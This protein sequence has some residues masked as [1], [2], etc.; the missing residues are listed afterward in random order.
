MN[1]NFRFIITIFLVLFISFLKANEPKPPI[2]NAFKSAILPGWG[3]LSMGNKSGY[4]FL[5]IEATLWST[6]FYFDDQSDLRLRQADQFA[7]NNANLKSYDL[8]E[9]LRFLLG[10]FNTSGF[11]P[12]GYN[13]FVITTAK[14]LY[15]NQP[16]KQTDYINEHLLDE[17]I[18]WNWESTSN[19]GLYAT[20]RRESLHFEDY[21]KAVT[22]TIIVNHI[23]SFLNSIRIGNNQ[24]NN[25]LNFYAG[26][27]PQ[28]K[29]YMGCVYLF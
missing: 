21:A 24:A 3:E 12:G 20:M 28:M 15:P 27:N 29:P 4:V 5:A 19:R 1:I 9:N 16:D 25:N 13:E 17:S 14:E 26:F 11:G 22:G 23:V 6:K 7:F 8:D 18:Y 2:L 10:R